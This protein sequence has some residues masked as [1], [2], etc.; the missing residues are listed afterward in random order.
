MGGDTSFLSQKLDLSVADY[1]YLY[2]QGTRQKSYGPILNLLIL[3]VTDCNQFFRI[4]TL[5]IPI[6]IFIHKYHTNTDTDFLKNTDIP[7]PIPIIPI[8]PIIGPSLKLKDEKEEKVIYKCYLLHKYKTESME[9]HP[10]HIFQ[11]YVI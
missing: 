3:T 1:S 5:P 6:P 7:I 10:C 9:A 8:I 2:A 4:L 11:D